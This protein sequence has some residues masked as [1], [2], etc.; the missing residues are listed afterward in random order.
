[1]EMIKVSDYILSFL[2]DK[3]IK[4]VFVVTGAAIADLIDAFDRNDR[5]K[6]IAMVH[7]QGA[8]FAS[9]TQ[10]KVSNQIGV[11]MVTSGPGGTNLVT[12]IADCWYDSIPNLFITGQVG[13]NFIKKDPLL[14][15]TG[16]QENDIVSIVKPITKFAKIVKNANNIKYIL[17]EA[18]FMA[19]NGRPGPV[20]IDIPM[21]IQKQLI[22]KDNLIGFTPPDIHFTVEDS[23]IETVLNKI[24]TAERPVI[25][26]GGGVR[27]SDAVDDMRI[28]SNILKIPCLPT[29]N[30]LD[31]IDSNNEFYGGRVGTY[32]APGRN[33]AIQNSDLLITIGSRISGRITGGRP[34][35][36]AREAFKIIVDVDDV[37]LKPELQIVKGDLNIHCDAKIF[38]Q[39]L[40]DKAKNTVLNSHETWVSKAKNWV[41]KYDAVISEYNNENNQVNPYVFVSEL[42]KMAASNAVIVADCGG[43]V[44]VTNQAFKTQKNQRLCSSNGNSPMGY[45]LAGAIG[46]YFADPSRQIICIIGDGG[47]TMNIQELQTIKNYN[48]PLKIFIMNNHVYGIIKAFQDTNLNGRYIAS[49]PDGYKPPDFVRISHAYGIESWTINN[50]MELNNKINEVLNFNGPIVCDVNT[51]NYFK[52]E[53][54]IFGWNTPIEDMYPYLPRDEFRKNMIIEP[55]IGWESPIQPSKPVR[56]H[57]DSSME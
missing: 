14:R 3:G 36:F 35:T 43:N 26:V 2:E 12:G 53:P 37:N 10:T 39:S 1:M 48:I 25:L 31:I 33:F 4:N 22:D 30:A 52:Y 23:V 24:N 57:R 46:A 16:F 34:E 29:W 45:S 47:F 54:R 17:E 51:D 40:I 49:G 21:D 41:N 27:L 28:L 8:S 5:I 6:Y 11:T 18:M 56:V 50:N 7:E 19:T 9:E 38:I 13:S 55:H 15:Q 32:G 20:L 42:S 44:V